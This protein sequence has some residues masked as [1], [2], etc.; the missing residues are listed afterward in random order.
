MNYIPE[1]LSKYNSLSTW[2]KIA[3]FLPLVI[4]IIL[5]A[6]WY[7][8][9]YTGA[10]LSKVLNKQ[11]KKTDSQVDEILDH[12]EIRADE[13]EELDNEINKI[14]EVQED[15]NKELEAKERENNY[16][17]I[18]HDIEEAT[19]SSDVDN[20]LDELHKGRPY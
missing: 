9:S 4:L 14:E 2:K 5:L 18:L 12:V 13:I 7:F 1:Y 11:S 19:T 6:I 10:N 3:L 15:L 17:K 8:T 20:I 16:E